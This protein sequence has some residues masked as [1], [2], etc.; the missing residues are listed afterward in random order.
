[1]HVLVA[2]EAVEGAEEEGTKRPG[3]QSL[4]G[5]WSD[6]SLPRRLLPTL[7]LLCLCLCSEMW[8]E[9]TPH[10]LASCAPNS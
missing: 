9:S 3:F 8:L 7:Q 4:V 1:M 10:L 2:V 6:P 5:S